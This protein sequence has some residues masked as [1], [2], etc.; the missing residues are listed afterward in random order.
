MV[1]LTP[2]ERKLAER[3]DPNVANALT[4]SP[5]AGGI[6]FTNAGQAMEM[7]KLMALSNSGV[8]KHLRGNPGACLAIVVQAVEW[9][10]SAYAVANKSYFVTTRSRSSRNSSRPSSCAGPRSRAASISTTPAPARAGSAP[11]GFGIGKIQT[12]SSPLRRRS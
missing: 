7:A 12:T 11:R 5:R 3:L 6:S 9:G 4:I 8:R 10:V 1:D 2:A